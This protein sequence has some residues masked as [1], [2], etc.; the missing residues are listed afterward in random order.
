M[1]FVSTLYFGGTD[2]GGRSQDRVG[3]IGAT[4]QVLQVRCPF[5]TAEPTATLVA[6]DAIHLPL[7]MMNAWRTMVWHGMGYKACL[8]DMYN[9]AKLQSRGGKAPDA[10]TLYR[11][12]NLR[13][14]LVVGPRSQARDRIHSSFLVV[15]TTILADS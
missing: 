9:K 13:R 14:L 15:V 3:K 1:S 7:P 6:V 4:R 2:G 10:S 5:G 12:I 11:L 8:R